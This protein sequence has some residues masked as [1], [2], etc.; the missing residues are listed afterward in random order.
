MARVQCPGTDSTTGPDSPLP[1][2]K[3]SVSACDIPVSRARCSGPG[4]RL[5]NSHRPQGNLELEAAILTRAL[6]CLNGGAS[7]SNTDIAG[8]SP[9]DTG[10]P[11]PRPGA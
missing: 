6:S 3:T 11:G 8:F 2:T 5:P 7:G 1:C 4:S 9:S 10:I